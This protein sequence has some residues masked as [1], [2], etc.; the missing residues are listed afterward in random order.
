MEAYK[1][2]FM[3][4]QFTTTMVLILMYCLDRHIREFRFLLQQQSHSVVFMAKRF[5]TVLTVKK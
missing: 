5:A 3:Q 2:E 4:K 1:K